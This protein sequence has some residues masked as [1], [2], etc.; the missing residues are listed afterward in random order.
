MAGAWLASCHMVNRTVT[1]WFRHLETALAEPW[2]MAQSQLGDVEGARKPAVLPLGPAAVTRLVTVVQLGSTL[3]RALS[4]LPA[5]SS[6]SP[7]GPAV[8]PPALARSSEGFLP[9]DVALFC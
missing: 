1:P 8:P 9:L 7:Q 2:H 3:R 4:A 6:E 5:A